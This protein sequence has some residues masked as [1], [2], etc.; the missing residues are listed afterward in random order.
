MPA[1]SLG[2]NCRAAM[3]G[4]QL[5]IRDTKANGYKT[6][7]FDEM[8]STYEGM[9]MCIAE[10]FAHFTNPE[11]L[12]LIE[13]PTECPY[14]PGET[15]LY[16]TRYGFIFNHESP[17]HADLYKT[18]AWPGGK[19]HYIDDSFKYFRERYD[20]RI[21][22]FRSYCSSGNV[23]LLISSHPRSFDGL[24]AILRTRYPLT[25]FK[26]HRFDID[27]ISSWNYHEKLCRR[28]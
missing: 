8:N 2:H 21:A 27:N 3:I 19:T 6:C 12:R 13:H 11:Y 25:T 24:L 22:N 17:G 15:L 23:T 16:N 10:D 18:Q 20:R 4:V 1:I 5:G 7:P 26:V 9:A 28:W 14:Y